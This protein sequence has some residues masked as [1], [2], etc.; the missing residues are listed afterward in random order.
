MVALKTFIAPRGH[1]QPSPSDDEEYLAICMAVRDQYLD[2]PKLLRHHYYHLDIRRFYIIGDGSQ[3]PL[4]TKAN[5]IPSAAINFHYIYSENR[6]NWMQYRIY[7]DYNAR[8][9]FLHT[10][11]GYLGA[12]EYLETTGNET[13]VEFLHTVDTKQIIGAVGVNWK[14]H[15]SS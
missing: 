11:I 12:D 10:C 5:V 9:N 7:N 13:F 8:Y 3:P 14:T 4:F 15:T 6:N 2:I 1:S